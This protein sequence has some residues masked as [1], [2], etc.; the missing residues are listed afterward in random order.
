MFYCVDLLYCKFHKINFRHGVSY[1][2]S[3]D[4]IKQKS[5]SINPKNDDDKCFQY[6]ATIALNFGENKNNRQRVSK[7]KPFIDNYNCEVI[8][9]PSK[10]EDWK[11]SEKNNPAI[12]P[13]VLYIKEKEIY[14]ACISNINSNSEKKIILLMIPND[15]K[16][17]GII[18]P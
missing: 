9:Y 17:V 8:N 3:L 1:I 10:I 4:W 11:K 14:P 7:I 15:E 2:D 6:A 12:A 13:R 5:V 16:K 18:L